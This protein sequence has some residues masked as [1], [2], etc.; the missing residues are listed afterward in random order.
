MEKEMEKELNFNL[1][2]IILIEKELKEK[3]VIM[4]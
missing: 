1:K 4:V 2:R 3:K